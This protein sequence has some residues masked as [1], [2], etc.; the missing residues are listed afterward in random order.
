VRR[1]TVALDALCVLRESA[2]SRD[3]EV[4]PALVLAELAGADA[5][6]LG[7]G[8]DLRPVRERDVREARAAARHFELRMPAAQGLL[9]L[10]LEVRPDRVVFAGENRDTRQPAGA[11]DARTL[12]SVLVPFVRALREGGV[13]AIAIVPPDLESVKAA[14]AAGL[15]G[16][17][18]HTGAIVDLPA[19]ERAAAG[20]RLAD[21]SRLAAK[22]RLGL[23]LGGGLGYRTVP[24]LLPSVPAVER[25]AVGRACLARATLVGLDRAVRDLLGAVA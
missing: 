2:G 4:L 10:A 23:S 21:A 18:L 11:V 13:P 8:E 3:A 9:K 20:E 1:L 24:E 6:R 15:V 14:H 5:I 12:G 19:A 17:E 25:V 7:V 16:V 22:L